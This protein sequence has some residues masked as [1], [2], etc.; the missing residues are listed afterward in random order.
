MEKIVG[1][2]VVAV[3]RVAPIIAQEISLSI[4]EMIRAIRSRRNTWQAIG[5]CHSFDYRDFGRTKDHS[6]T[7]S[8]I[9]ET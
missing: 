9:A 2:R 6:S 8:G 5:L 4:A 3:N 7:A 1:R